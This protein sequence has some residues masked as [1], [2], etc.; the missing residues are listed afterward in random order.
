MDRELIV[1]NYLLENQCLFRN[2]PPELFY[3][4]AI[5][6]NFAIFTK[7]HLCWSLFSNKFAVFQV[8]NFI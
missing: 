1:S 4:K 2:H 6:K 3:K 7:K 5:L 8:C